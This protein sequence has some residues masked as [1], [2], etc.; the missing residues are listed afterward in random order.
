MA[1]NFLLM[2]LRKLQFT[3]L[4][5]QQSQPFYQ[6]YVPY[7]LFVLKYLE[8]SINTD[9]SLLQGR[10]V[11]NVH[12]L[13]CFGNI[14]IANSVCNRKAHYSKRAY[15]RLNEYHE[16]LR[17]RTFN[18]YTEPTLFYAC[19]SYHYPEASVI[20][21]RTIFWPNNIHKNKSLELQ[22]QTTPNTT[23]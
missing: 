18:A 23:N 17:Y 15:E 13:C 5:Y 9:N 10:S 1:K 19:E 22:R 12:N 2:A 6:N 4:N 16:A 11:K 21:K 8:F 7:H 3:Y 14:M 20:Y